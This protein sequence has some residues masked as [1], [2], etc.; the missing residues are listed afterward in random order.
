MK[1]LLD[2]SVNS[3]KYTRERRYSFLVKAFKLDKEV[4]SVNFLMG[5]ENY[6]KARRNPILDYRKAW[7]K[8]GVMTDVR[9]ILDQCSIDVR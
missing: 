8:E 9:Y 7:G 3:K 1:K 4:V 6:Q 2:N 5:K